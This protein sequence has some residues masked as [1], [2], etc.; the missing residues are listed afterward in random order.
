MAVVG[1]LRSQD[2]SPPNGLTFNYIQQHHGVWTFILSFWGLLRINSHQDSSSLTRKR[3]ILQNVYINICLYK[4]T[5]RQM[6]LNILQFIV[7]SLTAYVVWRSEVLATDP[8]VLG[9]IPGAN[10]SSEK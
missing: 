6:D 10:K 7:S 5:V 8:E 2:V 1:S 9:S 4:L 3:K